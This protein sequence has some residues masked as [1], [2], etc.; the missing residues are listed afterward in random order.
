MAGDLQGQTLWPKGTGGGL[1]ESAAGSDTTAPSGVRMPPY[2]F[3]ILLDYQL[4]KPDAPHQDGILTARKG[5]GA[6][7]K[8]GQKKRRPDCNEPDRGSDFASP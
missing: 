6:A 4:G 3:H 2:L 8:G 1:S 7:G 5:E